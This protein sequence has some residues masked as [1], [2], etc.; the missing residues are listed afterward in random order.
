MKKL[1]LLLLC[2]SF[3]LLAACNSNTDKPANAPSDDPSQSE[4][5]SQSEPPTQSE[6]PSEPSEPTPSTEEIQ[7]FD[8]SVSYENVQVYRSSQGGVWAQVIVEITNEGS[9]DIYLDYAS[10]ELLDES[11][12]RIASSDSVSSFPNVVAPGEKGYYYEEIRLDLADVQ[13]LTLSMQPN[14]LL[15]F[16]PRAAYAVTAG[17]LRDSLYGGV[18]LSGT[19]ENATDKQARSIYVAAIAYDAEDKPIAVLYT[20]LNTPLLKGESTKFELSSFMLPDDFRAADVA[21]MELY[22]YPLQLILTFS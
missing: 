1:I 13:E 9:T 16:E 3:L 2:M 20:L 14:V 5:P 6:P 15:A 21:R 12:K 10:F 22:A 11:G 19:V 17:A 8:Y 18:E 7:P 4:T